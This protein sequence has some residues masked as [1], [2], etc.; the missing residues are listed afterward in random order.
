MQGELEHVNSGRVNPSVPQ[1]KHQ[2]RIANRSNDR[3]PINICSPR[4]HPPIDTSALLCLIRA[5]E[6]QPMSSPILRVISIIFPADFTFS[7][8]IIF[9]TAALDAQFVTQSSLIVTSSSIA[10]PQF[11]VTPRSVPTPPEPVSSIV[12][13]ASAWR[14]SPPQHPQPPHQQ[15][16]TQKPCSASPPSPTSITSSMTAP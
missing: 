14:L 2:H 1:P 7:S 9:S 8:L 16:T 12:T 4:P 10:T 6:V 15:Q 11:P 5:S 13:N 3:A